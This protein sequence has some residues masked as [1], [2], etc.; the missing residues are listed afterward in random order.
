MTSFL[1]LLI[2]LT[3]LLILGFFP[4]YFALLRYP[5]ARN[6]VIIFSL[7]LAP[8]LVA[9]MQAMIVMLR[10]ETSYWKYSIPLI[11]Y[12]GVYYVFNKRKIESPTANHNYLP[13]LIAG[14]LFGLAYWLIAFAP[15]PVDHFLVFPDTVWNFGL[16]AELKHHFPPKDPHWFTDQYFVYHFIT[17]IY[18]AGISNFTELNILA[19]VG[20]GNLITCISI[21]VLIALSVRKGFVTGGLII[22]SI[23]LTAS[24]AEDWSVFTSFHRHISSRDGGTTFFWSIPIF[25]SCIHLWILLDERREKIGLSRF[26]ALTFF[27][28]LVAFYSKATYLTVFVLLEFISFCKYVYAKKLWHI[29][30]IKRHFKVILSYVLYPG[31]ILLFISMSP[32]SSDMLILG[33]ETR[34]FINFGSWNPIFPF[35]AVYCTTLL[36]LVLE[37]KN[38]RPFRWEFILASLF[39]FVL[40]L[41]VKHKGYSDL[42]FAF[43]AILLNALFILF[44]LST[45]S[46]LMY[47]LAWLLTWGGFVFLDSQ[48]TLKGFTPYSLPVISIFPQIWSDTI[49]RAEIREY[50][51]FS[52]QL[53]NHAMIAAPQPEIDKYFLYS[54]LLGKRIWNECPTYVNTTSNDYSP[55]QEFLKQETFIP[56]YFGDRPDQVAYD[57][58]FDSFSNEVVIDSSKFENPSLRY[59]TY[60]TCVFGNLPFQKCDSIARAHGWTHVLVRSKDMGRI[61]DWMKSL[62]RLDGKYVSIFNCK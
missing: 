11:V 57:S 61:N 17:N 20:G 12:F 62:P 52:T 56:S 1:E 43:N 42:Y 37:L 6:S 10:L 14:C 49:P 13:A 53:D 48:K 5:L 4:I 35:L 51:E 28:S 25:L 32:G 18:L 59:T 46:F 60:E 50:L 58:A 38:L 34:D 15:F 45:R 16:I 41:V 24:F 29:T 19:T 47:T 21:F 33:V 54:A 22:F 9:L 36:F 44:S 3:S 23:I 7:G 55:I 8:V 31:F 2:A 26:A 40:F 27:S 39:N 30:E